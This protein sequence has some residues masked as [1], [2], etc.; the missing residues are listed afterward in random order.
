MYVELTPDQQA[1]RDEV[2]QYFDKLVPAELRGA[3]IGVPGFKEAIQQMGRDGWLGIAWPEEYGGQAR[4][5]VE[6]MIFFDEAQRIGAPFPYLSVLAVG[7]ALMQWGNEEQKE[8]FLPAILRGQ[9]QFA[10][11]Y[12][13]AD[14]GTDLASLSTRA[15][16]D[17]DDYVING[18]KLWTSGADV[19]DYIWLACRTDPEGKRHRGLS[20]LIVPTDAP[21]VTISPVHTMSERTN[22]VFFEDVRVPAENLVGIEHQGWNL[23]MTQLNH[24]RVMIGHTGALEGHMEE[25]RRWAQSA[26]TPDGRRVIDQEW[27]QLHLAR[28]EAKAEYLRLRNFHTAWSMANGMLDPALASATKVFSSQFYLEAYRALLE[29][30]GQWGYL[31]DGSPGAFLRGELERGYRFNLLHTFGGGTNEVQREIIGMLGLGLP[32]APR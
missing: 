1:L 10:I 8:R 22:A 29:V 24:E 20:I 14:A 12:S 2:R 15:T 16:R 28:V 5:P 11:G 26:V 21:G 27:V 32:R 13:E 23:I 17:G 9:I 31:R 6:L 7:P 3:Y 18:A 4:T 19:Y 30:V 25:V